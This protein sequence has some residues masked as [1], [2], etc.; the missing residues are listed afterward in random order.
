MF[1][2]YWYFIFL[3]DNMDMFYFF[4]MIVIS[5]TF[6]KDSKEYKWVFH[7]SYLCWYFAS[8]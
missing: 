2:V 4:L 7:C 1:N 3:I 8:L 6:L 5:L